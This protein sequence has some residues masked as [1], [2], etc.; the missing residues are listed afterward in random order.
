MVDWKL[1]ITQHF[2]TFKALLVGAWSKIDGV[3]MDNGYIKALTC[4]ES[5]KECNYLRF[6]KKKTS[7]ASSWCTYVY[8]ILYIYLYNLQSTIY[9]YTTL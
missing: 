2:Q 7:R 8:H 9:M 4:K 6:L 5:E 1:A 3:D